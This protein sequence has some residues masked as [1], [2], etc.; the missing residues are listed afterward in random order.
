VAHPA[1]IA[2]LRARR[3]AL[4]RTVEGHPYHQYE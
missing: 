4:R 2:G 1:T 3:A